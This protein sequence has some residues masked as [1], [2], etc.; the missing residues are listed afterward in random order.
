MLMVKGMKRSMEIQAEAIVWFLIKIVSPTTYVKS[1]LLFGLLNFGEVIVV[2]DD[3]VLDFHENIV[4]FVGAHIMFGRI[5]KRNIVSWSCLMDENV[6]NKRIQNPLIGENMMCSERAHN[7]FDNMFDRDFV[8]L[9]C[10]FE[11]RMIQKCYAVAKTY[12]VLCG[13]VVLNHNCF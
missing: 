6:K 4:C 13:T 5:P 10:N 8:S 12:V 2:L 7:L 1:T 9:T 11:R 3:V